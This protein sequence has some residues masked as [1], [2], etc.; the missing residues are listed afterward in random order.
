MPSKLKNPSSARVLRKSCARK[1]TR[2]DSSLS[3]KVGN[4]LQ[5]LI[6]TIPGEEADPGVSL[7]AHDDCAV[8]GR[9]EG[10]VNQWKEDGG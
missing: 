9:H 3:L 10:D 5:N 8:D 7:P 4:S 1:W 6:V 2:L